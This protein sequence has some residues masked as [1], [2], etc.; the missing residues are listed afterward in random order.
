MIEIENI[1]NAIARCQ[2]AANRMRI[3]TLKLSYMASSNGAH[4]GSSLSIVEIL[5]VVYCGVMYAKTDQ[6]NWAARDRFILSKGH[7]TIAQYAA[8]EAAKIITE[9]QLFTF[10]QNG[11]LLG[12]TSKFNPDWGIE[13]ANGSL[14]MGL[15]YAVGLALASI[16]SATPY[17][18]Y[19]LLGDGE[20]NEG[21]VWE[22]AM[23]AQHFKLT[24]LTAIIDLNSMQSDGASSD[25]LDIQLTE[26]WKG[27]GW[28]VITVS[29]GHDVSQLYS[30]LNSPKGNGPR[31]IVAHTVK[32][33][34]VSFMEN[35]KEWHHK[36]LTKEMFD[37]AM[38]EI[39]GK[40]PLL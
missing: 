16:K 14:G 5:A 27:Y 23:S 3:N 12:P 20:C 25:V 8:L 31:V 19:A 10:N 33:K 18:V 26:M 32:G 17:H 2:T 37:A 21:S 11:G 22:A 40:E 13:F 29:D 6:Q 36:Q 28:E 9:D 35:N 34:G 30:A 38:Q 39:I 4:A 24:N 15:S 1:N 7:G